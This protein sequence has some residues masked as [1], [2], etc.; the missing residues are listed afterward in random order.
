MK[1]KPKSNFHK[2][3]LLWFMLATIAGALAYD[4]YAVRV[5]KPTLS[6]IVTESSRK[7]LIIPFILGVLVGHF[8][9]SQ[10]FVEKIK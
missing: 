2:S 8:F 10:N 9:W 5:E 3:N 4:I 7:Y 1:S 6:R